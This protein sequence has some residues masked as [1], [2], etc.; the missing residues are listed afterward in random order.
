MK[1]DISQTGIVVSDKMDKSV[2]VAV[3][4]LVEHPVYKKV[5]RRTSKF[6]AHDEKNECVVGDKV[7]IVATRP[8]SKR[9]RWRV[10]NI[11]EKARE[12]VIAGSMEANVDR[13]NADL[14]EGSDSG[15]ES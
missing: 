15:S 14:N 3:K 8:L 10:K 6:M 13:E 9:K 1:K 11:I 2:V 5:I 12:R 7:L 4:R